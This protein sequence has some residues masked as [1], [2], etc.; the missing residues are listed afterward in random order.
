MLQAGEV[1]DAFGALLLF[2]TNLVAI[3]LVGAVVFVLTGVVPVAQIFQN[4]R[5]VRTAIT[6]IGSLALL[7][8]G[9][10]GISGDRIAAEGFQRDEARAAVDSWLGDTDLAVFDLDVEP[11]EV[12]VTLA[13]PDRPP[14]VDDLGRKLE[15]TLD[16]AVDVRVRWV[17]EERFTYEV[18]D[19]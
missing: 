13:G 7:V 14:P 18:P 19:R 6:L 2:T 5:W 15:T 10:L 1:Q 16:R 9:V 17:P 8:I 4:Q 11:S 3:L 12:V